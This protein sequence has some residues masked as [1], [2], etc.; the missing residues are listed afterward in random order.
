MQAETTENA[1][2]YGHLQI[3]RNMYWDMYVHSKSNNFC[4]RV[5]NKENSPADEPVCTSGSGYSSDF[6]C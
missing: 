4:K 2:T 6:Q 3:W 1:V 5:E